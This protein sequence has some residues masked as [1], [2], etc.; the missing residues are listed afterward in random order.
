MHCQSFYE[1]FMGYR[2]T[3]Y[4]LGL[5]Y[6]ETYCITGNKQGVVRPTAEDY[7][8]YLTDCFQNMKDMPEVFLCANDFVALDP[9]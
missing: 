9:L 2:N 8:E 5:P 4:L 6:S 3:L 1:R 7:K